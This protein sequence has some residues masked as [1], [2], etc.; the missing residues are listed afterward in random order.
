MANSEA[1]AEEK[2]SVPKAQELDSEIADRAREALGD[3]KIISMLKDMVLIRRFEQHAGRAY[4][5]RKIKGFCHLYSGQEG[6]GVGV[7]AALKEKDYIVSHYREHGHAIAR[8]MTAN[9]VMAELFGKETGCAGGR[10]GSMHLYDVEKRFMGG[11][12]IVGGQIALAN[13]MAFAAKYK[14]EDAVAINFLGDGAIHQGIVHESLNMAQLWKLPLITVVEDNEYA[15]GT[16]LE[17]VSAVTDLEKKALSYDMASELV[18]GQDIFAVWEA[19]GRARERGVSGEGPTWLHI[20]TYRYFGHSMTDP[21]TYRTREEVDEAR[22]LRDPIVRL[23]NWVIEK[24]LLSQEKIDAIDDEMEEVVKE[25]VKF[26]DESDYPD[27]STLTDHV[28]A[29]W[30]WD[31]E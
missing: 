10:G 31:F 13:G 8:G 14:E 5:R 24:E 21:A 27:V 12:G 29:D 4:Q 11:W 6:L 22:D 28:Y 15:M 25:S 3:E 19:I 26:A 1:S 7:M 9:S 17:R 20:K 16:A 18:D 30:S 23:R 2:K